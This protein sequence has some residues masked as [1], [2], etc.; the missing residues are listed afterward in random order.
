MVTYPDEQ[1]EYPHPDHLRV[2]EISMAAFDA[3]GDPDRY[4]EAGEPFTPLKLY[5]TVWPRER[6]L[7][8]AREVPRARSRI[9]VRRQV[10]RAH[11][12]RDEP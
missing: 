7:G 3:A 4:P 11:R 10:A 2:H 1:T 8:D 6:W 12:S 9:P 5:Y